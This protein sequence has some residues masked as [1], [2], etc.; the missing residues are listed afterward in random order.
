[1]RT[2]D[3]YERLQGGFSGTER[4][5]AKLAWYSALR[6]AA[7]EFERRG[8]YGWQLLYNKSLGELEAVSDD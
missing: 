1:M 8:L 4:D 2:F 7:D 3:E 5:I 6:A